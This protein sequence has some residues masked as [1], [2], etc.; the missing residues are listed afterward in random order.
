MKNTS[1]LLL[2]LLLA[3]EGASASCNIDYKVLYSIAATERH[4]ARDVGYPFLISFN[5][6]K[7]LAKLNQEDRRFL[8]DN[9]T[10][11]CKNRAYCSYMVGYLTKRGVRNMDLGPFQICY[12]YHKNNLAIHSFFTIKDSMS[13]A[14]NMVQNNVRRHGCN[15]YAIARYH[16]ATLAY[17]VKYSKGLKN[18]YYKYD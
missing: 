9:R 11:D 5:K 17:N 4:R 15:W 7:D 8:L 16:S 1:K 6:R 13:Y 2:F 18:V 12:M 10:L 14:K 3:I